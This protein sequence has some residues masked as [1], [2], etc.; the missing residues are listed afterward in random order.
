MTQAFAKKNQSDINERSNVLNK[1]DQFKNIIGREEELHALNFYLGAAAE[2]QGSFILI[3]GEA[4]IGKTHLIMAAAQMA[5]EN[6]FFVAEVDFKDFSKYEPFEPF[7][8]LV[9]SL[10]SQRN[11]TDTLQDE[12]KNFLEELDKNK[13]ADSETFE[14]LDNERIIIQQHIVTRILDVSKKNPIFLFLNSFHNI[15][16]TTL[17]F[18]HYLAGKFTDHRIMICAALRQDGIETTIKKIPAYADILKRMGREGLVTKIQ[19]KGLKKEHLKKYLNKRYSKSDLSTAFINILFEISSGLPSRFLDYLESLEKQ[20]FIYH[21]D[22]IWYNSENVTKNCIHNLVIDHSTVWKIK[23]DAKS[24]SE[25]QLEILKIAVLFDDKFD[26]PLLSQ[27]LNQTKITILREL[28]YLSNQKFLRQNEDGTFELRHEA[29][30]IVIRRLMKESE[31]IEKNKLIAHTILNDKSIL[32]NKKVF[33]LAKHFDAAN[34]SDLAQR[35][36][37]ISGNIALRN[38]AF[39]EAREAFQRALSILD[40]KSVLLK[41][42]PLT[43]LLLKCAWVDRILGFYKES[44]AYCERAEDIVDK[45]D[46]E[47]YTNLLLQKGLILFRLNKW[48]KSVQCFDKCLEYESELNFFDSALASY[49]IASV[50]FEL[51][52]YK[53]SKRHF[54]RALD[55]VKKTNNKS[56]EADILNNLG[57]VES[58]TGESLKAVARYSE[59]IPIYESLNDDYGL[60]QVYNNLGLTY[61]D[62]KKWQ[63]AH[64]CY[65]KSLVMCDKIG[66][67]P[68]KSIVF[69]NR[70]FALAHLNDLVTA[71]EYNLKALRLIERMNDQL[72]MAEYHKNLGVIKRKQ[73]DWPEAKQ[74]LEKAMDM[75]KVLDHKLG[76]AETAYELGILAFDMSNEADF[77]NWFDSAIESYN[78]IGLKQKIHAIEEERYHLLT[79]NH[80]NQMKLDS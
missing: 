34:E 69:L 78:E 70:A 5:A 73:S 14:K 41:S 9:Q 28:E 72:S 80:V 32:E 17:Q 4:G 46:I 11:K 20:G 74:N 27:L 29:I 24:L 67:I 53:L 25:I 44:L 2:G 23:D 76:Y 59:S 8:K 55:D 1:S 13:V 40:L 16:Q 65:R 18:I 58:V 19:L 39:A 54:E 66:I 3:N 10:E 21:K 6:G 43:E 75:Y 36:L 38:L 61:A 63:D 15:S 68:L 71:E 79:K 26:Y 77:E 47:S 45:S 57:A 62:G 33:L 37:I 31:I 50:H 52:N 35:Y 64:N 22:G 49:G 51:G 56:F 12:L 48:E 42:K 30:R 7:I 60:A